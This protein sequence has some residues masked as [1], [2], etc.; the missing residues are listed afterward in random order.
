MCI[1][2]NTDIW[3]YRRRSTRDILSEHVYT[4]YTPQQQI[5]MNIST[6]TT[7]VLSRKRRK[8][9]YG[10]R[11]AWTGLRA[12]RG[13][14]KYDRIAN[15]VLRISITLSETLLRLHETTCVCRTTPLVTRS[16]LI[17]DEND[18]FIYTSVYCRTPIWG[19]FFFRWRIK[20]FKFHFYSSCYHWKLVPVYLCIYRVTCCNYNSLRVKSRNAVDEL[21]A[22]VSEERIYVINIRAHETVRVRFW[23]PLRYLFVYYKYY[24]RP[25]SHKSCEMC[26]RTN[27]IIESPNEM[28]TKTFFSRKFETHNK[29]Y[30]C[31]WEK[32]KTRV[33]RLHIK[34]KKKK[35]DVKHTK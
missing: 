2:I 32:T 9:I 17:I 8:Y 27:I 33:W 23:N 25:N 31:I 35:N 28:R 1:N 11:E 16:S 15:V 21:V 3:P 19:V 22:I 13:V 14:D 7:V 34:T 30:Y 26:A 4:H 18:M 20:R 5:R 6:T 24:G 12:I 29:E 10:R